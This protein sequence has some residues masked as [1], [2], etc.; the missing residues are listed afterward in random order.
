VPSRRPKEPTYSAIDSSASA[1]QWRAV[2]DS[3][4]SVPVELDEAGAPV[5]S[6]GSA[7]LGLGSLVAL[8]ADVGRVTSLCLDPTGALI[9]GVVWAGGLAEQLPAAGLVS[10]S[11]WRPDGAPRPPEPRP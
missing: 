3:A 2:L 10:L 5:D 7:N 6:L 8:G 9:L 11:A 1:P 4:G